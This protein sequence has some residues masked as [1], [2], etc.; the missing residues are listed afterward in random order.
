[1][2]R[3]RM[4]VAS[5]SDGNSAN[6]TVPSRSPMTHPTPPTRLKSPNRLGH[7]SLWKHSSTM[8]VPTGATA[9]PRKPKMKLA[10]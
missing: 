9:A 5:P 8:T 2:K 1:M 10:M 7:S 3:A 4:G 6:Q